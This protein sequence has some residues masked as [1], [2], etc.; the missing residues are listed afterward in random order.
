VIGPSYQERQPSH[1]VPAA[2]RAVAAKGKH[3]D[4]SMNERKCLRHEI[5]ATLT[6]ALSSDDIRDPQRPLLWS[7][8]V[9]GLACC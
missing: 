6:A 5:G 2:F 4:L 9:G 3:C 1:N 8:N 7:R